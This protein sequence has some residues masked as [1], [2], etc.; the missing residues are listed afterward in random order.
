[1]FRIVTKPSSGCL[2]GSQR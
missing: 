1:M 2:L